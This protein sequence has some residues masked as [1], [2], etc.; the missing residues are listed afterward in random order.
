MELDVLHV[1]NDLLI[2]EHCFEMDSLG[3]C[4]P[5]QNL[6]EILTRNESVPDFARQRLSEMGWCSKQADLTSDVDTGR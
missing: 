2:L 5:N 3:R 4:L 6:I 1:D